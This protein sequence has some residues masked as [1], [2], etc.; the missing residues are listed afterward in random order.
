MNTFRSLTP[1]LLFLTG[2]FFLNFVGRI[3][4]GPL[5]LPL[6]DEFGL[7]LSRGGLLFVLLSSGYSIGVLLAGMVS[8]RIGHH[9]SITASMS[10][11][12]LTLL[13]TGCADSYPSVLAA[14]FMLGLGAGF[15]L[16]SGV[17]T[18]TDMVP[19]KHWG[20]AFALHELAP[21]LSFILA[22]VLVE[23][24]VAGYTWRTMYLCLGTACL[25][26]APLYF[27]RGRY[28]RFP[29][30]LPKFSNLAKVIS[31]HRFQV[32]TLGLV[33]AVGSEVGIYNLIP[34]YL[35]QDLGMTRENANLL[36]AA[37]RMTCLPATFAAGWFVDRV[38]LRRSMLVFLF[39]AAATTLG[40]AIPSR[41]IV[42]GLLFL[43]PVVIIGMFPATFSALTRIAPPGMNDLAVSV[44]VACASVIG[45]G[46]IPAGLAILGE[47]AGFQWSYIVMGVVLLASMTFFRNIALDENLP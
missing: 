42:G 33:L 13:W 43:Q 17:A 37:S 32:V 39:L 23:F 6:T 18:I 29:G 19:A 31:R 2:I 24:F 47:N 34:A 44:S 14:Q 25:A 27:F 9:G 45:G 4:L 46:I 20:K 36:L 30:Q 41:L 22:P 15:Y 7:S 16:P 21:S 10:L 38:G 26:Y 3:L 11:L 28:G 35:V 12:G 5:L 40:L 1:P 8:A